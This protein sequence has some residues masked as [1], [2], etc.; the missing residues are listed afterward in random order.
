MPCDKCGSIL[1]LGINGEMRKFC[2][3][4]EKIVVMDKKESL[5]FVGGEL[6]STNKK[7]IEEIFR[8]YNKKSII[9][10]L[11][12]N[13]ELEPLAGK[14]SA[15]FHSG[16]FLASNLALWYAFKFDE[17]GTKKVDSPY[18]GDYQNIL[19]LA[20]EVV[21]YNNFIYLISANFGVIVEIPEDKELLK[22][23]GSKNVLPES[24]G[25]TTE[26][27]EQ[28]LSGRRIFKFTE[29]W[30]PI[31]QNY[32]K[33][34]LSTEVE[35][36]EHERNKRLQEK[37][38]EFL[39][40]RTK[41]QFRQDIKIKKKEQ[42][43][44][45][46]QYILSIL[47]LLELG[48]LGN[49]FIKFDELKD[50]LEY[51]V[52]LLKILS[53]WAVQYLEDT[54]YQP[55]ETKKATLKAANTQDLFDF[56]QYFANPIDISIFFDKFV[57]NYGNFRKFPLVVKLDEDEFLI[58]PYTL[59]FIANFLTFK[60]LSKEKIDQL[61]TLEGY[62]F[63][64]I[65]TKKIRD[66]GITVDYTNFKDDPQN[67]TL[68]IDIIAHYNGVIF[69]IEC[70]NWA[71]ADDFLSLREESRRKKELNDEV[72]K[73][74]KRLNYVKTNMSALGFD[75]NQIKDVKSIIITKLHEQLQ[76]TN[77]STILP[78]DRIEE[79]LAI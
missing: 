76:K 21:E 12:V 34:E 79:L 52:G 61:K 59:Y 60:H 66:I 22:Y 49:Y 75:K 6:I 2:P 4:C 31:L 58:P 35:V 5:S 72:S 16:H 43:K 73:Q 62:G 44:G 30:E 20:R 42:K 67:P 54:E 13:R 18:E 15:P 23:R 71:L 37:K 9:G 26:T 1:L 36:Y 33:F 48:D 28:K 63:E 27:L 51:Y 77:G 50:D 32:K 57:S 14:Y 40:K 11:V 68:E 39:R 41:T 70:K 65:V 64:P 10:S 7:K 45:S 53:S 74:E 25:E 3:N 38:L 19:Y 29:K 78:F 24:I 17:F 47:N 8:K 56:F 69:V 55:L 46:L